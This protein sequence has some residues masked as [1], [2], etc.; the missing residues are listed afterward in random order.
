M[1]KPAYTLEFEKPLRELEKHLEQLHQQS[2][3]NHLDL[4]GEIAALEQKIETTRQEIYSNLTPGSGCRS[5]AIPTGRT[6][7]TTSTPSSKASRSCTA[8]AIFTMTW[9]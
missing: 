4:S 5:P 6:P 7:S 2:L 8:T 3:E 1:A 9:R